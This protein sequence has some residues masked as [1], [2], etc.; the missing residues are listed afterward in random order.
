[1]ES[2]EKIDNDPYF[3]F[4]GS[5][6]VLSSETTGTCAEWTREGGAV[7]S[8]FRKTEVGGFAARGRYRESEV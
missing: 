4:V 1:M 3:C 5:D 2:I 6:S 8:Q 7:D